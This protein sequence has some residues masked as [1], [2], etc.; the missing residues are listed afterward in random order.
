MKHY[1]QIK[2]MIEKND[3]ICFKELKNETKYSN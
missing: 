2:A 3:V 1:I